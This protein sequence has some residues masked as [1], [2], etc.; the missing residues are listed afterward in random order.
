MVRLGQRSGQALG[1]GARRGQVL[2]AVR[3]AQ[4]GNGRPVAFRGVA[5]RA[6]GAKPDL[7]GGGL[8]RAAG[9]RGKGP[10]H[11]GERRRARA[12]PGPRRRIGRPR[13]L[14]HFDGQVGPVIRSGEASALGRSGGAHAGHGPAPPRLRPTSLPTRGWRPG[15]LHPSRRNADAAFAAFAAALVAAG[16]RDAR[17][18]ELELAPLPVGRPQLVSA[19]LRERRPGGAARLRRQRRRRARP[20]TPASSRRALQHLLRVIG[21]GSGEGCECR[22]GLG[23]VSLRRLRVLSPRPRRARPHFCC[24]GQGGRGQGGRG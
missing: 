12:D 3:P 4:R 20:P 10:P 21:A 22:G 11:T 1:R 24:R 7:P 5:E 14:A 8:N 2:G 19:V 23:R 16:R 17:R 6:P 9:N 13:P 18:A 15:Q